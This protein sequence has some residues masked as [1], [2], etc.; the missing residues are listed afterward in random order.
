M[1]ELMAE[2]L[3][4]W[5]AN[6]KIINQTGDPAAIRVI[7][8]GDADIG[9]IAVSSAINSGLKIFGPRDPDPYASPY[10]T[11]APPAQ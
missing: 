6:A 1:V 8:A 11:P 2:I 3:N 7:L 9:S 10:V 4:S 5:G